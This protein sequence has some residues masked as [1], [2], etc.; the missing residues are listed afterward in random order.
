MHVT[1]WLVKTILLEPFRLTELLIFEKKIQGHR[2][3]QDP[4]FILGHYRSGTTFLY[5]ILMQNKRFGY[6]TMFQ[7]VAP[8]FMLI[9]EKPLTPVLDLLARVFGMRNYFH[10][11]PLFWDF[12]GEDDVG[13]T[14]MVTPLGAQWSMMFPE[15]FKTHFRKTVLQ[16][17]RAWLA[18]Y[19]YLIKKISLAAKGKQL[20]LKSP[21]NTAR[22]KMLLEA[23][24]HAKFIYI[25]RNPLEVYGSSNQFWDT[26]LKHYALGSTR[27]FDKHEIILWQ[28]EEMLL[29]YLEQK[30]L[31]PEGNLTEIAYSDLIKDP[32]A[33]TLGIYKDLDLAGFEDSLQASREFVV[34]QQSYKKLHH[35]KDSVSK[36]ITSRWSRFFEQWEYPNPQTASDEQTSG[37]LSKVSE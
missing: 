14:A 26:I 20:F 6:M 3:Q 12:P 2:L 36:E 34:S 31:I 29:A 21:P 1:P 17:D 10:R 22:I 30:D 33:T 19:D 32:M 16:T 28:Y 11:I 27:R 13:M 7:S 25:H 35:K 23:Y 8:E 5:R 37:K 18:K 9:L 4:I 15:K 24:P